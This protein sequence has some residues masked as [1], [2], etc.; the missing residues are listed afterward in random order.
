[1]QWACLVWHLIFYTDMSATNTNERIERRKKQIKY[2]YEEITTR[3][4]FGFFFLF[5]FFVDDDNVRS[6]SHSNFLLS[7]V[8]C[9]ERITIC[10]FVLFF[11][12]QQILFTSIG[13]FLND[14]I[15]RSPIG[16]RQKEMLNS[17]TERIMDRIESDKVTLSHWRCTWTFTTL[18]RVEMQNVIMKC[19]VSDICRP[20]L[21]RL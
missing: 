1:M 7:I 13:I 20:K 5:V 12:L 19:A 10:L 15:V 6:G 14:F 8:S 9:F 17:F 4:Q 2:T 16:K 11:L 3:T 18:K 21:R